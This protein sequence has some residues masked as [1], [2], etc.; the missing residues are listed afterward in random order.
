MR[1]GFKKTIATVAAAGALVLGGGAVA[2]AS[3]DR[4]TIPDVAGSSESAALEA[5]S[6]AGFTNVS[7]NYDRPDAI[8]LGTSFQAGAKVNENAS[9]LVIVGR[10]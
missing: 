4:A 7:V 3:T 1:I 8:V 2:Q 6:D 10:D 9:I 5:L